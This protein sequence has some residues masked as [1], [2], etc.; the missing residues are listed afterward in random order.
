MATPDLS[1][2]AQP[3]PQCK[4]GDVVQRHN[5]RTGQ[6]FYGCSRYPDCKFAVADLARLAPSSLAIVPADL[7]RLAEPLP[8]SN[9]DASADLVSVL[10][11]LTQA[12]AA[13][14]K[15]LAPSFELK[16]PEDGAQSGF[17]ASISQVA[18]D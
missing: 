3:C 8:S 1:D 11:E 17:S 18:H 5:K 9:H 15:Q 6:P 10:R 13:L 2:L 12:I 4:R 14:T 16:G 7:A